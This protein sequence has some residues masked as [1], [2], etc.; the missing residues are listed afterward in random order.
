MFDISFAEILIIAI[1]ALIVVGPQRLPKVARTLGYLFGRAQRYADNIKSD[2]RHEMELEELKKLKNSMQEATHTFDDTIRQEINQLQETRKTPAV[3]VPPR[4][5]MTG[6]RS[7]VEFNT[8][9]AGPAS[10][11]NPKSDDA[12]RKLPDDAGSATF[13]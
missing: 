9:Q 12:T 11:Q 13:K 5:I 10:K 2:I 8:A 7:L 6:D 1:M 3:S 4:A